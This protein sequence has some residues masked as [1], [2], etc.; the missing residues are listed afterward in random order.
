[1]AASAG[2]SDAI[3]SAGGVEM[4][5]RRRGTGRPVLLVNGLGANVEMLA[6][7]EERLARTAHTIAVELPG[8]GRSPTPRRPLSIAAIAATLVDLLDELGHEQVD[9]LGFSLGGVVAQQL[10]HD[11]PDRVRR[12]ALA[13]TACGWGSLPGTFDAL[14]LISMPIRYHSRSLYDRTIQL[15]SPADR[16]LLT[17]VPGLAEAR[18]LHPPSLLGYTYQLTAGAFWSSL[19]W[20][21][22]VRAPTLVLTGDG[23]RLVQPANGIQLARLLPESRLH[24]LAGEGHLYVC[25]P[26]SRA[27][28]LLADFFSSKTLARC[29]AWTSGTEVADDETVEAAFEASSGAQPHRALSD[30]FR[31]YVRHSGA[32]GS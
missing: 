19:P 24:V 9:V 14:T 12:L 18:L 13:S 7:L 11:A 5:V 4:F 17:R 3:L 22:S 30:A 31:R 20:L 21:S 26:E 1:M 10:A 23:D 6:T 8:A 15:A 29:R 2:P 25:D 27:L 28:P 16:E 32:N